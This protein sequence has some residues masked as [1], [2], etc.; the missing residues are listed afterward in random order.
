MAGEATFEPVVCGTETRGLRGNED[1]HDGRINRSNNNR[2]G[3]PRTCF[4]AI[5]DP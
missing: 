3:G 4:L 5:W 1:C 2:D